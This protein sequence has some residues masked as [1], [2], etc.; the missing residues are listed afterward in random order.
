M[1]PIEILTTG[2][3]RSIMVS[4]LSCIE[5]KGGLKDI[6]CSEQNAALFVDLLQ[7]IFYTSPY[8]YSSSWH[9]LSLIEVT[10]K[11]N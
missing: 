10:A 3:L 6:H 7:K 4:Y 2:P 9:L 11:S 1:L 5:G 8:N